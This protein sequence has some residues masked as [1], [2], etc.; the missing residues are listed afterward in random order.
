MINETSQIIISGIN[1]TGGIPI[2]INSTT[3]W[4]QLIMS[5]MAGS[6]VLILFFFQGVKERIGGFFSSLALRKISKLTKRHVLLIKHTRSGFF[7]SSMIE[8]KTM[9]DIQ[10]AIMK[11]KGEPFDL[12]LHTPGG[13]V[14]SAQFIS[15]VLKSYPHEIRCL[16]P[17]Y[18][19]S[20]GT[21]LM[22]SCDKIYLGNGACVGPVDVQL[23][24]LF[25]YGSAKS[26]QEIIRIK[27]K[28]AED[29]SISFSLMGKQ[30]T[31]SMQKLLDETIDY[32]LTPSQKK[33][34]IKFVTEGEVE[35]AY[36]LT[37]EKLNSFGF[38]VEE[39]PVEIQKKLLKI[40][41]S[42]SK[43]GVSFR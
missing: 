43:E 27:G 15:R 19:M 22:L 40:I 1:A 12:V 7:G 14:F 41:I 5:L 35:H 31:K 39:I 16:I 11:F 28:K 6:L 24:N 18:A 13:E 10:K 33:K 37:K 42:K 29:S 21:L 20:G 36:N 8:Q 23:G 26:W 4:V 38:K 25:K 30:Y 2:N 17:N 9:L 3:N 34:F 32:G